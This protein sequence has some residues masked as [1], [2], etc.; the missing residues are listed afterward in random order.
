MSYLVRKSLGES[1]NEPDWDRLKKEQDGLVAAAKSLQADLEG[2]DARGAR[3]SLA[4]I[5]K[6]YT[7][8]KAVYKKFRPAWNLK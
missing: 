1:S 8:V 7:Q 3:K 2:G 4:R 5:D 6:H